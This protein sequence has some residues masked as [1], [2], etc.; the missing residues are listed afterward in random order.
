M[1]T[2]EYDGR[3]IRRWDI[4]PSTFLAW[5]ERGARL[6]NWYITYA[7]ETVRDVIFW[8]A[9]SNLGETGDIRG[10]NPILFPFSARTF[11]QGE[12]HFWRHAGIRRP[13]P[14]HGFV[15]TGD[16]EVT[17]IDEMGFTARFLPG[18]ADREAYPFEYEFVVTYKFRDLSLEVDLQLTNRETQPIPWSAGHHFYFCLPWRSGTARSDYQ[19]QHGGEKAW[20]HAAIGSLLPDTAFA[21]VTDFSDPDLVDRIHTDLTRNPVVFGPKDSSEDVRLYI[22]REKMPP[23]DCALTT[24]TES[25]DAPFY[26][27]EPWMGPPNSPEHKRGLHFVEAGR[28]ETFTVGIEVT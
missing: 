23:E 12:I 28:S 27:V 5:P 4:G 24:W 18:E 2:I 21:P 19:I 17:E 8:P 26:C 6:I 11:D 9:N 25:N 14:M 22:G 10:G 15:R 13:M 7:D 16:F 1:R 20:R 3:Q